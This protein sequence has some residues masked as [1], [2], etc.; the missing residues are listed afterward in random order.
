MTWSARGRTFDPRSLYTIEI[1]AS[2][3]PLSGA[4]Q[5][6]HCSRPHG[7]DFHTEQ[8]VASKPKL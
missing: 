5:G 2:L 8:D 7:D 3:F 4:G 6:Q 1:G